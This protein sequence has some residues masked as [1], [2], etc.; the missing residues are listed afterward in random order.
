MEGNRG[1][2][3]RECPKL[4]LRLFQGENFGKMLVKIGSDPTVWIVQLF[5]DPLF[6]LRANALYFGNYEIVYDCL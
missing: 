4:F 5:G 6:T 3:Y 2:R 1:R